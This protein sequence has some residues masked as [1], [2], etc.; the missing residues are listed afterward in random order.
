LQLFQVKTTRPG[1]KYFGFSIGESQY[2]NL[3]SFKVPTLK[4]ILQGAFI[5]L[6]QKHQA[7]HPSFVLPAC[8]T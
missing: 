1:G 6:F 5:D 8:T 2:P 3:S 7:C 4:K